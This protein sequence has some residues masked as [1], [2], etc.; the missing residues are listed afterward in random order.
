MG[1]ILDE[2]SYPV[3]DSSPQ[4][5][6]V[7]NNFSLSDYGSWALLSGLGIPVG[8]LAGSSKSPAFASISGNLLRPS[9]ATGVAIGAF[10]GFL[11]AYQNSAGRLMGFS[12]NDSEV[13][14]SRR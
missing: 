3:V 4:F 8:L 5:W 9:L 13:K 11:F 14:A 7:V 1:K 6:R 2:P 10:G 12:K